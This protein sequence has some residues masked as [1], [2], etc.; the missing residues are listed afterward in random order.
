MGKVS[1]KLCLVLVGTIVPLDMA[2]WKFKKLE[3]MALFSKSSCP[4]G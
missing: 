3:L 4:K 1:I 2:A